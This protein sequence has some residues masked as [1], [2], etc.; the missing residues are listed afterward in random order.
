MIGPLQAVNLLLVR[1]FNNAKS[2]AAIFS[3]KPAFAA[4][5]KAVRKI[6]ISHCRH[7]HRPACGP[8]GPRGRSLLF[9][10][11]A[12]LGLPNLKAQKRP[13][14]IR[15]EAF[16]SGDASYQLA[17]FLCLDEV[18]FAFSLCIASCL[19]SGKRSMAFSS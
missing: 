16:S 12:C 9:D 10:S 8:I 3:P 14:P 19:A 13:L 1:G 5:R 18:D 4:R 15:A 6:Q 7:N 2:S 11:L 17:G